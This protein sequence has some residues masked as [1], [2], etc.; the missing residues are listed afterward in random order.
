MKKIKAVRPYI[1]PK[2]VNFKE[3]PYKAWISAKGSKACPFYPWRIFHKFIFNYDFPDLLNDNEARLR[4]VD[5]QNIL[6]EAF[7]DYFLH[8]IVPMMWDCW[9]QF[10]TK[11][12]IWFKKHHVRTAIFSSSQVAELFK[13]KIPDLNGLWCPEAVDTEKYNKGIELNQRKID[14]LEL[15]R[16]SGLLDKINIT[17]INYVCTK[18]GDRIIYSEQQ[19]IEIMSGSKICITLPRSITQPSVACNI[20]TLTQRYWECMLSRMVMLGH[21]PE[22]LINLIGYN[23]VVELDIEHATEQVQDILAHIEDYQSLVDKNRET[24]LK[25]GDWSVRM[26]EVMKWLKYCGYEV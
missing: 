6:F 14:V 17:D 13:Q 15:G 26:Q 12:F 19:L 1:Y 11:M 16:I 10:H 23:P 8:E 20:E 7:P 24:A 18:R 9:P 21:A 22:E 2:G 4:F 5:P 25:M 3:A